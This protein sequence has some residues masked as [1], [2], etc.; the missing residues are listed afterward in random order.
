MNWPPRPACRTGVL[1]IVHGTGRRPANRCA[2]HPDVRAISFTGSTATGQRIVQSAGLK[3][4]SMELGGKSPFVVFDDADLDRALDAA[5]FMIFSQQRRALHRRLA[6]PG[7]ARRIYADFARRFAE[8]AQRIAVG[9][10][11]DEKTRSSAR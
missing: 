3:K 8:R 10:P 4:F 6:H 9:D 5:V 2:R 7:A 1:N 11:L